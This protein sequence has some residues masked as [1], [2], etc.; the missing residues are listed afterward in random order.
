VKKTSGLFLIL[1]LLRCVACTQNPKYPV[2]SEEPY[3]KVEGAVGFDIKEV[4]NAPRTWDATYSSG[5]KTARFRIEF[6]TAKP[7]NG[8]KYLVS[9]GSGKLLREPNSDSKEFLVELA[10]ALE[11]KK[12]PK[13]VENAQAIPFEYVII[14]S[15]LSR[16]ADGGLN[17]SPKGNWAAAKLFFGNDQGEVF[18]NLNPVLGK[19]EFSIKDPDYG[20]FVIGEL[21]K[22]L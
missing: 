2:P 9:S 3:T 5:G 20:D 15:N 12:F 18:L 21:A 19:A 7:S 14:S 4:E 13:N 1:L 8:D 22:I 16:A 17:G 10:K 11:A 6:D